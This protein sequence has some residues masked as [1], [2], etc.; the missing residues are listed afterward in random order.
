VR[1]Y[2]LEISSLVGFAIFK[3]FKKKYQKNKY[4][5]Q[6]FG[7]SVWSIPIKTPQEFFLRTGQRAPL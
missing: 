3:E 7:L 2:L 1:P 6:E 5:I 4:K